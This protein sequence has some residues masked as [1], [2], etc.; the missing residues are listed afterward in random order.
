MRSIPANTHVRDSVDVILRLISIVCSKTTLS[1]A[2]WPMPS[3]GYCFDHRSSRWIRIPP[4]NSYSVVININN[5]IVNT[6]V[7][8]A[9]STGPTIAPMPPPTAITLKK[10]SAC[11]GVNTSAMTLQNTETTNRG[12]MLDSVFNCYFIPY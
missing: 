9:V 3:W 8:P 12:K 6:Y 10:R 1:P 5:G 11:S 4:S 7:T 2:L